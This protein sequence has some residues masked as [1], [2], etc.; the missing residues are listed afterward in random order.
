MVIGRLGSSH[1]EVFFIKS[2]LKICIKLTG[3]HL[4]QSV[5]SIK[6]LKYK[7]NVFSLAVIF[8]QKVFLLLFKD[9][10]VNSKGF[11]P[12]VLIIAQ[13]RKQPIIM[14]IF[15]F[16]SL[17]P[18]LPSITL[19]SGLKDNAFFVIEKKSK[20]SLISILLSEILETSQKF[21]ANKIPRFI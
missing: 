21:T 18:L 9:E 12:P 5:I 7:K 10:I 11:L 19:I 1:L 8:L 3:E 14:I 13:F 2:V 16:F 17:H 15:C 20:F 6:S 4:C